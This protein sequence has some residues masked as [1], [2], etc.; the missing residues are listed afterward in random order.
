MSW[1]LPLSTPCVVVRQDSTVRRD[2][3]Y[4]LFPSSYNNS[5]V[6]VG[7]R[8]V[9]VTLAEYPCCSVPGCK[10]SR[11]TCITHCVRP[12]A[13]STKQHQHS[14][15]E[16]RSA[17]S[18]LPSSVHD[19]LFSTI[20]ARFYARPGIC[21]LRCCGIVASRS[22]ARILRGKCSPPLF[23]REAWYR[24]KIGPESSSKSVDRSFFPKMREARVRA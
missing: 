12:L 4:N 10:Q 6:A 9:G 1:A 11:G 20:Q 5:S 13:V 8:P 17:G 23:M 2:L 14:P 16:I 7:V 24:Y 3:A 19:G 21:Y 15:G 18:T 22:D